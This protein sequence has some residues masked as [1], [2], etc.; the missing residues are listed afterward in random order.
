MEHNP[1]ETLEALEHRSKQFINLVAQKEQHNLQAFQ[2][3]ILQELKTLRETL[4]KE[5][6][7]QQVP[8]AVDGG[9]KDKKI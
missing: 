5:T 7:N 8:Q 6:N 3:Q 9:E 1:Q 2:K 4:A